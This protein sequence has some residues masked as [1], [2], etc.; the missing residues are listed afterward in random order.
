MKCLQSP[1]VRFVCLLAVTL[2]VTPERSLL[3]VEK[4]RVALV[5]ANN[6]YSAEVGELANAVND[7]R[8]L[9]KELHVL[10][11][12]VTIIE[13]ADKLKMGEE[14]DLF[15]SKLRN[16]ALGFFYFAG[17]GVQIEGINYL[18]PVDA[19]TGSPRLTKFSSISLNEVFG[20]FEETKTFPNVV[21]LDCCRNNP[22]AR[23]AAARNVP[24][25]G[26]VDVKE[27]TG[28]LV[29]FS[30]AA[31]EVAADADPTGVGNSPYTSALVEELRK[32]P[33]SGLELTEAFRE[34]SRKV[35]ERTGQD[36][37][38]KI[39]GSIGKVVLVRGSKPLSSDEKDEVGGDAFAASMEDPKIKAQIEGLI[40][41]ESEKITQRVREEMNQ[42]L[43]REAEN[44]RRDE[45]AR[46][47]EDARRDAEM[48]AT[49]ESGAITFAPNSAPVLET[50]VGRA[51]ANPWLFQDS[52]SRYL[53]DDELSY[54]SSDD[55]WRA[56]NE[57]FARNGFIFS[58][59][60]GKH[61]QDS[62]G[63]LYTPR[64]SSQTQIFS[65]FNTYERYNVKKIEYLEKGGR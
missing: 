20:I 35:F 49:T 10:G 31:G 63:S 18:L 57:I 16:G 37:L 6:L 25:R 44:R 15:L 55:L 2:A 56:R 9:A 17:H 48:L 60:R 40:R 12:N 36:P 46:R 50:P 5:V 8:A 47:E 39:P 29:A 30:T 43:A 58:T 59:S 54:L 14:L 34:T 19:V 45:E 53:T 22:F 65:G 27:P 21:V 62:L 24:A 33:S 28:T 52:S 26:L 38:L 11:F 4:E 1:C 64:T 23:G 3:A 7:G 51:V 41:L 32:R 13:D 42:Q 61:F